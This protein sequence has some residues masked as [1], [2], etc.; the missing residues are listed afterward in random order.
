MDIHS[1]PCEPLDAKLKETLRIRG[2]KYVSL[3]GR[4]HLNYDG[5]IIQTAG[6]HLAQH[7][8]LASE[9]MPRP[10]DPS[11]ANPNFN[12]NARYHVCD[13]DFLN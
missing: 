10:G 5:F 8:L 7:M 3:K 1:L 9:G 13:L 4:H 11:L 6:A 2:Q 12:S